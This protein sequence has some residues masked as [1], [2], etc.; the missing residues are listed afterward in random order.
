M[1]PSRL[2]DRD[3]RNALDFVGEAHD[4]QD[5]DEFRA[6]ILPGYRRLVGCDWASYNEVAGTTP[7]AA[8]VEPELPDWANDAWAEHAGENPLLQRFLRTRD[9]RAVR[10]SDVAPLQRLRR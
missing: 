5:R 8:I 1:G 2:S 4:A 9:G 7:M 6:A 3:Y 10:F